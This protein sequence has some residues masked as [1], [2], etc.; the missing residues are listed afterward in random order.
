MYLVTGGLDV[1]DTKLSS[2]EQLTEGHQSWEV[3]TAL[4]LPLQLS[5]LRAVEVNKIVYLTGESTDRN[6]LRISDDDDFGAR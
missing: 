3:M 5:S 4:Q 1:E 2:T 6:Q